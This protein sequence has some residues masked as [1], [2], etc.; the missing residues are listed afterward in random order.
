MLYEMPKNPKET[1]LFRGPWWFDLFS[2]L[3]PQ[4]FII[5]LIIIELR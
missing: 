3:F 4:N 5:Y 2:S 1:A